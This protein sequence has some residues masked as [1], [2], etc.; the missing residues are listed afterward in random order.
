MRSRITC[1]AKVTGNN[2]LNVLKSGSWIKPRYIP[3]VGMAVQRILTL[4][5][6]M[7][8]VN[9]VKRVNAYVLLSNCKPAFSRFL[10]YKNSGNLQNQW[11][12]YEYW[13]WLINAGLMK[14]LWCKTLCAVSFGITYYLSLSIN[15]G[16]SAEVIWPR[17]TGG[18]ISGHPMLE[19]RLSRRSL[20]TVVTA[21]ANSREL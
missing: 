21:L 13:Y 2:A 18:C 9:K 11:W 20:W 5:R 14:H 7:V 8:N 1:L 3:V 16:R 15:Y 12:A 10:S 19:T 6:D 17:D 4:C